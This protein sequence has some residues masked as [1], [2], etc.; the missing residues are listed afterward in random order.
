MT[1]SSLKKGITID[2]RRG[3][4]LDPVSDPEFNKLA[5][6]IADYLLKQL[7]FERPYHQTVYSRARGVLAHE[8]RKRPLHNFT[9]E[10]RKVRHRNV[11]R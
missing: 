10:Y 5:E 6:F 4:G 1:S 2:K 9:E 3:S 7:Y 8:D 11:S